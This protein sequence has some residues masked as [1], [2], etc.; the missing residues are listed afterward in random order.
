MNERVVEQQC[1]NWKDPQEPDKDEVKDKFGT[2]RKAR[3]GESKAQQM[4]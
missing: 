3:S 2:R 4:E 1:V